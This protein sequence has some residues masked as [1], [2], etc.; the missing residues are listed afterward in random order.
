MSDTEVTDRGAESAPR[1]AKAFWPSALRMVALMAPRKIALTWVF[2]LLVVC[3]VLTVYAPKVLGDA[4]DVIYDGVLATWNGEPG[5]GIDFGELGRLIGIVLGM[6]VVASVF[7]WAQGFI[8]N[9]IV[10]AVIV[11]LRTDVER[12]VHR[13]P[14]S[15]YDSR[16]KGD[17]LSRTTND[18]DNVQQALQQAL[19]QFAYSG[20]MIIGVTVMMFRVSWQLAIV[21]LLAL[22][23]T[24][25]VVGIVGTRA[26]KQYGAQWAGTGKVNGHVEEAF[27]GHELVVAY[28]RQDEMSVTYDERNEELYQASAKAQFL[29]GMMMPLMQFLNYLSYV[30][31]AVF[32]GLRVANGQMSLG[33]ATAF[34]Q[35]SREFNQPLG[36]LAGMMT[37]VQSGVASAERVFELLDAEEQDADPS[38]T[39][40][41][42][43]VRGRV[44]FRDVSFG[45]SPSTPLI[46]H[47]NLDVEPGQTVAIVGPTG[48]GKTT[49]VNLIMRF[50]EVTG[51]AIYVDGV[52][53][54]AMGRAELRSRTGMV[55][56][57]AVLFDGTILENIRYGRLD[58]TDEEVRD[59]AKA[60]YVDRFVHALPDGYD[61]V[62]DQDG[63]SVS[64]GER[65]LITIARA[66]LAEPEIL[67]L[68]EATSS[69]DT[70]T[71]VLVQKAMNAIRARRTSFVI[72]HRLSTIR[73]AD[74]IL[75]MVD[76]TIVEQGSH[77]E[78][79][80][81]DGSY[82]ELYRSQFAA[83]GAV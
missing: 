12:K 65:Q 70:R 62:I 10:V 66:F 9:K 1:S 7:N 19:S 34:I 81:A 43:A 15:F 49:M 4:V 80:A 83:G 24:A 25:I 35:Y 6:Y 46:E 78:L 28:G 29:S 74:R 30:V 63:G 5:A 64:A 47:L 72:A 79:L 41:P 59:A 26:Q 75:V 45:Y 2:V 73:D 61:T 60:A 32:G 69:V 48:A 37:M 39:A 44:E 23:L 8:L 21:A 54:R 11:E 22:P 38:A 82:A 36:E 55:L 52:D 42:Q 68:D 27:T 58:A 33:A 31:I 3:V 17:L 50:Y 14:L 13:L 16:Q 77:D 18:V 51:G 40:S 20:M 67:I 76:G 57:D 53:S 71:E 56:Q